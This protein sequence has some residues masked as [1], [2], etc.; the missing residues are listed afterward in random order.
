MKQTVGEGF[1]SNRRKGGIAEE[2]IVAIVHHILEDDH[3]VLITIII[4]QLGLD[5]DVL[6]Q[7]IEAERFHRKDVVLVALRRRGGI[8]TVAVIS[9][10]E[11]RMEKVGFAVQ[12]ETTDSV[13]LANIQRSDREVRIHLIFP[14]RQDK[15]IQ[16]GI[17]GRPHAHGLR[18]DL[19]FTALKPK[20]LFA[21]GSHH[22]DF[23]AVN[24]FCLDER[25]VFVRRN[26]KRRHVDFGNALEPNTL[27][28][29]ADRRVPH[30]A[31]LFSLFAI[32]KNSVFKLIKHVHNEQI[33]FL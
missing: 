5:L 14:G 6:T 26:A 17:L 16:I 29:T 31:A 28:D 15:A 33:F 3:T 27:P 11:E 4:E 1:Q 24:A 13:Y 8:N 10:I 23:S 22:R 20:L 9:L 32:R 18:R 19:A 25:T 7:G 30:T 2:G 12:T 21:I